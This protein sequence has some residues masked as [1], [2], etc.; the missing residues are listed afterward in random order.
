MGSGFGIGYLPMKLNLSRFGKRVISKRGI[1]HLMDDMGR[2]ME[3]RSSVCMLGGGNPAPIPEVNEIWLNKIKS[4][5]L[6]CDFVDSLIRY[7]TPQGMT[8]YIDT[9]CGYFNSLYQWDL[10]PENIAITPGSQSAFF[11]LFNLFGGTGEDGIKRKI[12]F[13]LS[14]EY[15]GY[16]DQSF[17]EDV[18]IGCRGKIIEKEKPF[19]KYHV[20]FEAISDFSDIG[21]YC[22]SCPT[23]PTGNVVSTAELTHLTSLAEKKGIPLFLDSAYGE[24]FPGIVFSSTVWHRKENMVLG[25]SLSKLGLPSARVGII[26]AAKE[27][28]RAMTA[29]NAVI[30]LANGAIG[31]LLTREMFLSG[32][33]TQ[34]CRTV[35]QPYYLKKRDQALGWIR[36]FFSE[37]TDYR[38]HACEGGFFLW[39]WV[40]NLAIST[41]VLYGLLKEKGVLI[42][43]GEYFFFGLNGK[44]SHFR[45]CF[46]INFALDEEIVSRGIRIIGETITGHL[47]G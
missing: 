20:D 28:I 16:A 15:I 23:N 33:I 21:A 37:D 41:E 5:S 45:Q 10:E 29:G 25:F 8:E 6:S 9:L 27:V 12:L 13:P 42:V 18:F 44:D 43:P 31:Q 1:Y 38:I 7:E 17:E 3:S 34:I 46:R 40:R 24:P 32:E 35:I 36:E 4:L 26:V 30:S 47:S 19:F 39:I 2:A 22:L 11:I 14:P